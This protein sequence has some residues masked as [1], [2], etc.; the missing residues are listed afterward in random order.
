MAYDANLDLLSEHLLSPKQS[1]Y[2]QR[3]PNIVIDSVELE[4]TPV[5]AAYWY[6]ACERQRIFFRRIAGTNGPEYSHD[7]ILRSHRFTN[8]YRASDRVSQFLIRNVIYAPDAVANFETVFLRVLLFKLFNKIETWTSL[9]KTFGPVGLRSFD[10]NAF[11]AFLTD[12]FESGSRLY[13]AAYIMPSAGRAFG[14]RYK[15]SNHLRL[16]GHLLETDFPERLRRAGTMGQAFELLKGVPSLGPFLAYQYVTDLNYSDQLAFDEMEFVQAGPGA[17]DG[18]SKCFV[19]E[20]GVPAETIIRHFAEHQDIYFSRLGLDFPDLWGR[21]L[22]LIDC[23]NLF[24]EISKYSRVAFP[25]I[26]GRAGRTRIKQKFSPSGRPAQPWYPPKWGINERV[27]AGLDYADR[28]SAISSAE[29]Y[30]L[31]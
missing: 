1:N 6:F 16:L 25:E 20:K 31:F 2:C 26:A 9:E 14:Q 5:F 27:S 21:K 3:I 8:A 30:T 12:Q 23:Q 29:Q 7:K 19:D 18:I 15:H 17:L 11:D 22:Q 4:T 10:V 28:P 13:S 24:C